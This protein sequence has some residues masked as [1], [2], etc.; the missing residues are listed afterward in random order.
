MKVARIGDAPCDER[1]LRNREF[2]CALAEIV[3]RGFLDSIPSATQEDVVQ[4]KLED[5]LFGQV[6][7]EASRQ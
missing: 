6:S 5:S 7:F 2:A 4:I 3:A 1:C